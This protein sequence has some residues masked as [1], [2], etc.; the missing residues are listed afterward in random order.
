MIFEVQAY[1]SLGTLDFLTARAE[2]HRLLPGE[3]QP[4]AMSEG[5][6]P[7]DVYPTLGLQIMYNIYDRFSAAELEVPA[8]VV[9]QNKE[10]LSL[11]WAELLTWFKS[12]DPSVE[13][14][15]KDFISW[16]YGI[17]VFAP[18]H[19]SQPDVHPTSITVFSRKHF[20]V[21]DG[22]PD[23]ADIHSF[24]LHAAFVENVPRPQAAPAELSEALATIFSG[25]SEQGLLLWSGIPIAFSYAQDLPKCLPAWLELL[26]VMLN[27]ST[28]QHQLQLDCPAFTADWQLQWDEK[29]LRIKSHWTQA[30]GLESALNSSTYEVNQ[31]LLLKAEF[32][33]EWKILLRQTLDSL[34]IAGI[35]LPEQAIIHRL[36]QQL[37]TFGKFY[38]EE[39]KLVT[40]KASGRKQVDLRKLPGW[41]QPLLVLLILSFVLIPV[42]WLSKDE[43]SPFWMLESLPRILLYISPFLLIVAVIVYR[44]LSAF[45]KT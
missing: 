21:K 31:P 13:I 10:L 16:K 4:Q 9:F 22:I 42:W 32:L 29:F 28:G 25:T 35:H 8:K 33:A 39:Q 1:Q 43:S 5:L 6:S 30:G 38:R 3:S 15:D 45:K 12:L 7:I 34:D 19:R 24:H 27:Q 11:S 37:P 41:L 36:F 14:S 20:Y 18:E 17:A 23:P 26:Q 44:R 40:T 2:L